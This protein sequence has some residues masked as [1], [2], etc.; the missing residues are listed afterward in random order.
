MKKK[1]NTHD[2]WYKKIFSNHEMVKQLLTGFVSEDWVR[3]IDFSTLERL[4]KSFI[5]D[6]LSSR[7]SD[8]VYKVKFRNR[9]LYI[10]IFLEFQS[11]VDRFMALRMLR[12]ITEL[13]EYLV[14]NRKFRTLPA[15]FPVVLYNGEKRWTAPLEM[16]KLIE[17]S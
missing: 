7:E 12:Y 17:K 6:E 8:L 9:E 16:N 5:S 10:F 11:T 4:D 15:V 1:H 13:Y 14:K 2:S 3:E